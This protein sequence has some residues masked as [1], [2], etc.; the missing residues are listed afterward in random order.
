M[1]QPNVGRFNADIARNKRAAPEHASG[2]SAHGAADDH[3]VAINAQ[4]VR[5]GEVVESTK[6]KVRESKEKK[7]GFQQPWISGLFTNNSTI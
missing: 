7:K 1:V 4:T 5:E 2:T 3:Y 6:R